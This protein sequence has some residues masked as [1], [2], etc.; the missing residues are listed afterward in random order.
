MRQALQTHRG[1]TLI[2]LIVGLA[3]ASLMTIT[4]WR[5]IDGLQAA[6]DQ[7]VADSARWQGMD[8]FFATLEADLRRADFNVFRGDASSLSFQ[9]LGNSA[10]DAPSNVSYRFATANEPGAITI[11]RESSDGTVLFSSV[12]SAQFA[13]RRPPETDPARAQSTAFE[14]TADRFPLAIEIGLIL[15]DASSAATSQAIAQRSVSRMMVLR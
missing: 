1:M 3:I 10:T 11:Q 7:T 12:R 15:G 4:G 14:S 9:L 5:A 6:R 13:Y 8:T 2:E